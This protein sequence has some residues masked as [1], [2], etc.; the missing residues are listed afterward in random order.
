M[1][2]YVI[3]A[4]VFSSILY[5][6]IE[7]GYYLEKNAI[8]WGSLNH[9]ISLHHRYYLRYIIREGGGH[10]NWIHK[11]SSILNKEIEVRNYLEKKYNWMGEFK[12]PHISPSQILFEI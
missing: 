1:T 11:I 4:E 7:V 9:H 2:R 3:L 10:F 5:K 8:E 12:S 6:D